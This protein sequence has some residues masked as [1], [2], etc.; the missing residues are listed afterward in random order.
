M[1][2]TSFF[3]GDKFEFIDRLLESSSITDAGIWL[4]A[5]PESLRIVSSIII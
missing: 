4:N 1:V 3:G 2:Y 5:D